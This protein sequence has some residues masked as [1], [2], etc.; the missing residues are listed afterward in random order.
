MTYLVIVKWYNSSPLLWTETNAAELWWSELP[1]HRYVQINT[2]AIMAYSSYVTELVY[3]RSG[4]KIT[5]IFRNWIWTISL[6]HEVNLFGICLLI[7]TKHYVA[8][9]FMQPHMCFRW[10]LRFSGPWWFQAGTLRIMTFCILTQENK[11]FGETCCF[12]VRWRWRQFF[13]PK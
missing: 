9:D 10:G 4:W 7:T 11:R 8:Y 3:G 6:L 2:V 1:P 13:L 12:M 5:S